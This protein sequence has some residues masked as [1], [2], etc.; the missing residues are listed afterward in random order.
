MGSLTY[1]SKE[2]G[3]VGSRWREKKGKSGEAE[4]E[5]ESSNDFTRQKKN[6]NP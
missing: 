4:E 2:V 3:V 6:P 1:T 5:K